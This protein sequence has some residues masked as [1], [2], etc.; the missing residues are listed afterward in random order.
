MNSS[1]PCMTF[2]ILLW[3]IL[4][5]FFSSKP[6]SIRHL[7]EKYIFIDFWLSKLE[8]FSHPDYCQGSKSRDFDS[9]AWLNSRILC[10][11]A[12]SWNRSNHQLRYAVSVAFCV[13]LYVVNAAGKIYT[14]DR[15]GANEPKSPFTEHLLD[16]GYCVK[17]RAWMILFNFL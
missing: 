14:L 6:D 3:Q 2:K 17:P 16:M 8:S 15:A 7:P 11:Q 9:A 1:L 10:D 13:F 4:S 5:L 12:Y